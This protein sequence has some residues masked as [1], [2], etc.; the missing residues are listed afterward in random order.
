M[1]DN[2]TNYQNYWIYSDFI[3]NKG[4]FLVDVNKDICKENWSNHF[5]AIHDIL[6]WLNLN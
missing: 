4:E 5:Q 2:I 1:F 3:K 6:T